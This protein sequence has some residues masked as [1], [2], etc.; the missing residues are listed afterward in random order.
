MFRWSHKPAFAAVQHF[1]KYCKAKQNWQAW[2]GTAGQDT[3]GR[4]DMAYMSVSEQATL[5]S[6]ADM[7]HLMFVSNVIIAHMI[8]AFSS[9]TCPV[10]VERYTAA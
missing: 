6:L 8:A 10:S 5:D 7:K 4:D 2:H 3:A 9:P 1:G